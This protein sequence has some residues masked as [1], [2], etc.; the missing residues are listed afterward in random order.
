[1][2][3]RFKVSGIE[4]TMYMLERTD[5]RVKKH[6]EE[7]LRRTSHNIADL[8]GKLAPRKD[9]YLEKAIESREERGISAYSGRSRI[10]WIIE[11]DESGLG[12]GYS[13]YGTR[14]DRIVHDTVYR[15]GTESRNKAGVISVP[16]G[17]K[18]ARNKGRLSYVGEGYM[19]RAAEYHEKK[20]KAKML[21][22][23]RKAVGSS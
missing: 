9:G 16:F 23:V 18:R 4:S 19:I 14:Y 6:S 12:P 22:A 7:T 11:V 1:M 13:K 8:A 21:E 3:F 15:L 2:R 5:K 10:H 17:V 20:I